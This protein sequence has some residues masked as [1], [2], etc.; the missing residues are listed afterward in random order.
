MGKVTEE[1]MHNLGIKTGADLK[2]FTLEHL[3]SLFGKA[4]NYYFH[5]AHGRDNRPVEPDRIRKSYG[6][7]T[8]LETDID[9]TDQMLVI[10]DGLARKVVDGLRREGRQGLTLT[11]KIKYHDFKTVTR[12]VTGS[13]PFTSADLIMV[14]MQQLLANT[15]AGERKVRLLEI[16][17]SNFL[18]DQQNHGGWVQ[19]PLP[20]E[21]KGQP[22]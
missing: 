15:E 8:T 7:K 5:I 21:D 20:F 22:F 10:L 16:S 13:E 9:D 17:V 6:K 11:L 3:S 12:S 1:R 19:L 18:D 2:K 14:H 4:G